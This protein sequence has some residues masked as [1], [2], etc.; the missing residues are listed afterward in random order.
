MSRRD[1][2]IP[3]RRPRAINRQVV[4]NPS[5]GFNNLVSPSLIDDREFSDAQNIEYDEGGVARKRSGYSP[6]ISGRK[7]TINFGPKSRILYR[8][9]YSV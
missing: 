1:T 8:G 6:V 4:Y 9:P 5:K 3:A 7:K 2:S